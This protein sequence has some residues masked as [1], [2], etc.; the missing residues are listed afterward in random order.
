MRFLKPIDE[1]LLMSV[2]NHYQNIITIENGCEIGGLGSAVAEFITC[3]NLSNHLEIMGIP[4]KFIEQ[5]TVEELH[6]ICHISINDIIDMV[7]KIDK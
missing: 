6:K 5:G 7:E 1:Q 4:D 2:C 3:H